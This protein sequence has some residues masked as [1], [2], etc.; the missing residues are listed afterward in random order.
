MGALGNGKASK[1]S[2]QMSVCSGVARWQSRCKKVCE[3]QEEEGEQML[4]STKTG[5]QA[6]QQKTPQE[7]ESAEMLP[8]LQPL[9]P[10]S[11]CDLKASRDTLSPSPPVPPAQQPPRG[12]TRRCHRPGWGLQGRETRHG[13]TRPQRVLWCEER[14]AVGR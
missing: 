3:R 7:D 12:H 14:Q 1:G 4:C 8:L 2:A 11:G 13:T 9:A 6:R 10:S 5:E